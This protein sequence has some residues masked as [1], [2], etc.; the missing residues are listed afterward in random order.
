VNWYNKEMGTDEE[1]RLA[2]IKRIKQAEED[3]LSIALYVQLL[4]LDLYGLM[5]VYE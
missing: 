1:I 3:A 5:C 2:E 4:P